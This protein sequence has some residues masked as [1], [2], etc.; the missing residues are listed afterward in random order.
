MVSGSSK[1]VYALTCLSPQRTG[2]LLPSCLVPPSNSGGNKWTI[3][4]KRERVSW[5]AGGGRGGCHRQT[6]L[7]A[8]GCSFTFTLFK[9][10]N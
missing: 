2:P 4:V 3:H 7:K 10:V 1:L 9:N 8:T 5:G 6:P